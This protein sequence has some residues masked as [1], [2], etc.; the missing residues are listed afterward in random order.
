MSRTHSQRSKLPE[1]IGAIKFSLRLSRFAVDW[2]IIGVS[3]ATIVFYMAVKSVSAQVIYDELPEEL[4]RINVEEHLG[5]YIPLD[6][7]FVNDAGERVMLG[8][9]FNRGK[10]IVLVLAYYECP[11]LCNL[12]LNGLT[13]GIRELDW[14]PGQQ[15]QVLTVSFDPSETSELASAKKKTYIEDLGKPS[16]ADG[17]T[18]FVGEESQSRHLAEALG[19]QY[20][21][22]EAS[23]LYAHP[24]VIFLLAEDGK[25]LRYL[26]GIE[27]QPRDL[28]LGLL[29]A[30]QGK[31][32]S[33]VDRIILYCYHYDPDAKGY[34][35][36][37]SNVMRIGGIATLIVIMWVLGILWLRERRRRT[38]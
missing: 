9:Y 29:E 11:M 18:F 10:P 24:A 2:F 17:W 25:I 21:Y 27:F 19:F 36:F 4:K 3:L 5:E 31:I 32:G 28:R 20:Y 8:D 37:A 34:V 26:Y 6:L 35:M 23:D 14:L 33:A 15:F 1:R 38:M 13:D 7:V 12:V 22:D 16:T 30:S